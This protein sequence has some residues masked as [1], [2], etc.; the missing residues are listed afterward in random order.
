VREY[1]RN[2]ILRRLSAPWLRGRRP[3]DETSG[4]YPTPAV[5]AVPV[6]WRM[7][8]NDPIPLLLPA[9]QISRRQERWR[10]RYGVSRRVDVPIRMGRC[11]PRPRPVTTFG[12]AGCSAEKRKDHEQAGCGRCDLRHGPVFLSTPKDLPS[13]SNRLS[14][15]RET[16]LLGFWVKTSIVE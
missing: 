14:W 3:F 13:V 7:T 16:L 5:R 12:L 8:A 10:I 6:R 4:R 15:S 11:P 9:G 2:L 1:D